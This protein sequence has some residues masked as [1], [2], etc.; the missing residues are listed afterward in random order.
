MNE[1]QAQQV[2]QPLTCSRCGHVTPYI[3]GWMVSAVMHHM[4]AV[5]GAHVKLLGL[6]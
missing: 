2:N 1:K 3:P 6:R 5:H 4:A